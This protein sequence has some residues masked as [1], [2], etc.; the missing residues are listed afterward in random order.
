MDD[1][2][3]AKVNA[4]AEVL[5]D[6]Q[7]VWTPYIGRKMDPEHQ[8]MQD[9]TSTEFY[10]KEGQKTIGKAIL[11]GK[12]RLVFV[13]LGRQAGKSEIV[14]GISWYK[15]LLSPRSSIYYFAPKQKQAK[16]IV[17]AKKRI[18][19]MNAATALDLDKLKDFNDYGHK[20]VKGK[21]NNAEMRLSWINDS[22]IKVDGS[23]NYDEYRGITPDLLIFDEYR[24][25]RPGAYDAL[26]ASTTTKKACIVIISTPPP[27][28]G[29][30]TDLMEYAKNPANPDAV[31]FQAPTWMNPHQDLKEL[32][33]IREEY[34]QKGEFDVWLREYCAEFV[35]GGSRSIFPMLKGTE[36]VDHM[37]AMCDASKAQDY[38]CIADPG[39][40]AKGSAFAFLFAAVNPFTKRIVLMDELYI[41]EEGKK[42]VGEIEPLMREKLA[43]LAPHLSPHEW[44]FYYDEAATWFKNEM[45]ERGYAFNP[46]NKKQKSKDEGLSTIK[47]ALL[48]GKVTWSS[49]MENL[50]WEMTNYVK[51]DKGNIPKKD[52]HLIDAFRYLIQVS[53]YHIRYHATAPE[54]DRKSD[55]GQRWVSLEQDLAEINNDN[56]IDDCLGNDFIGD[57]M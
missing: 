19:T 29:F 14:N 41:T 45:V 40:A 31:F 8:F 50:M 43:E 27:G 39:S 32:G 17:W 54:K 23:D 12:H 37:Q 28:K 3:K 22:F 48:A 2:T 16:E 26:K 38:Y 10:P 18:Q 15:G 52:D 1:N 53:H 6:L 11:S 5:H 33:Q 21:P 9:L 49:R 44:Q 13:Q 42:T 7:K 57:F 30:Y 51:D 47:D 25:F 56:L 34:I 35:V 24:D 46:T 20:Y 55:G 4:T 36:K